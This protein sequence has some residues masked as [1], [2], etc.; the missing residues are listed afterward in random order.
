MDQFLEGIL[1]FCGG[2][3]L[4]RIGGKSQCPALEKHNL[5]SIKSKMK[6][7]REVPT[8]IHNGRSESI[9]QLKAIQEQISDLEKNIEHI[10]KTVLGY[11]LEKVI[12]SLNPEHSRQLYE[13]VNGRRFDD[14]ILKWLGYA[15]TTETNQQENNENK[16]DEGID[17]EIDQEIYEEQEMDEE[18]VRELEEQR[19]I[20]ESADED[21]E[22]DNDDRRTFR[23]PI[24]YN[25]IVPLDGDADG[26]K[27]QKKQLKSLKQGIKK[28][29]QKSETMEEERAKAVENINTLMPNDR[30]NLYRLWIK[31][32]VQEFEREIK[33]LRNEYRTE[34]L[35]FDGLRKQE[36]IE[37]VKRAQIIG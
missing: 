20:Q 26:F 37:I 9:H 28:E 8:H 1:K 2:I 32:Y 11:E 18:E 36:D 10:T 17:V 15:F 4:I 14:G 30:W 27:F 5:A 13:L 12:Q 25:N 31:L 16:M 7:K 21:D 35:R 3:E 23:Q 24:N 6:S 29:I 19:V 33:N 34:C 22:V